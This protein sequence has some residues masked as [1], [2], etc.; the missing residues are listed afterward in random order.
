MAKK[1]LASNIEAHKEI[2]QK[3]VKIIL[4]KNKAKYFI[5]KIEENKISKA[6]IIQNNI[7]KLSPKFHANNI[8]KIY[9]KIN[10]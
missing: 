2:K 5:K 1:I 9:K 6:K 3:F 7:A 4:L 10:S 8:I